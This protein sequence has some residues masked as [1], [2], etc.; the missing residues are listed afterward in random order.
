MGDWS[1]SDQI[2]DKIVDLANQ[3]RMKPEFS[4]TQFL[5]GLLLGL[6][7]YQRSAAGMPVPKEFIA[8]HDAAVKCLRSMLEEAK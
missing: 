8:V 4:P 3:E 5:V 1:Y 2:S 7:G 6:V